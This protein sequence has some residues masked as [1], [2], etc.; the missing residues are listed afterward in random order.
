M[1]VTRKKCA[2]RT[3]I[4]PL[5]TYCLISAGITICGFHRTHSATAAL[6]AAAA[7]AAAAGAVDAAA[8]AVDAAAPLQ[9]FFRTPH[10]FLHLPLE[11]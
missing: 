6:P 11:E 8:G 2:V 9:I 4:T 3:S 10:P 7:V 1:F 5:G